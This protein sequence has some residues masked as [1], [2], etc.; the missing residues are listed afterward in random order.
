MA[1]LYRFYVTNGE[2]SQTAALVWAK[3]DSEA[4]KNG[5]EEIHGLRYRLLA[6]EWGI[7]P[8]GDPD[9]GEAFFTTLSILDEAKGMDGSLSDNLDE[10]LWQYIG[11]MTCAAVS[12]STR[13]ELM[14]QL[15]DEVLG[16]DMAQELMRRGFKLV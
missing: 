3:S 10:L 7:T 14:R 5:F 15:R 13:G 11:E 6:K 12:E 8:G 4:F 9:D 16:E 2:D 1:Q